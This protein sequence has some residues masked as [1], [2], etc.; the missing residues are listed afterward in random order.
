MIY[1]YT[2]ISFPFR[3][4]LCW[5]CL[6][7]LIQEV[8]TR[9][10]GCFLQPVTIATTLLRNQ[11]KR[12]NERKRAFHLGLPHFHIY[13]MS[14]LFVGRPF[15]CEQRSVLRLRHMQLK[16]GLRFIKALIYCLKKQK[17]TCTPR[18]EGTV[19]FGKFLLMQTLFIKELTLNTPFSNSLSSEY[20]SLSSVLV[21][22][23]CSKSL[24]QSKI[25]RQRN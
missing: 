2:W 16:L 25:G 21:D 9:P 15:N 17:Q 22:L 11:N 24:L 7:W 13:V 5:I 19:T 20:K 3:C 10:L 8:I 1:N 14:S 4:M 6:R 23:F 18:G 12:I